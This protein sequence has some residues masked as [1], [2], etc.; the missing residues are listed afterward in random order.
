MYKKIYIIGPVGSGKTTLA[1]C[2]SKKYN[3]PYYELDKVVHDDIKHCKRSNEEIEE[4][5]NKILENDSFIVEDVG[6]EI[7][8]NIRKSCDVIYYIK[9]NRIVLIFRVIRRYFKRLF[10][11]EECTYKN[12]LVITFKWLFNDLK[13]QDNFIGKI[14]NDNKNVIIISNREVNKLIK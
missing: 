9:I 3:I 6:R 2:L 11:M 4:L 12:S 10:K 7:L 8:S 5:T 13:K 1:K 14:K